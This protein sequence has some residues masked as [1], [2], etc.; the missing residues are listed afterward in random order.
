M[1]SEAAC[2]LSEVRFQIN[3]SGFLLRLK[4]HERHPMKGFALI[5]FERLVADLVAVINTHDRAGPLL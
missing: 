4:D 3:P 1:T 5:S 2:R